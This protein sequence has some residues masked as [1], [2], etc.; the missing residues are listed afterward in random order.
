M[1]KEKAKLLATRQSEKIKEKLPVWKLIYNAYKGGSAFINKENLFQYRIE[2]NT[3]YDKRLERADYTNHIQQLVDLM[4]G[5]VY[6]KPVR[7]DLDE[8]YSYITNS[9]FKG[10]DIQI[11]MNMVASNCLKSTVGLLVDSPKLEAMTEA[12]RIANNIN[13]YV[14]YYNPEQICDF[15]T[16]DDGR[17]IWILLDNSYLDKTDPYSEPKYKTIRRLWTTEYYQ[18]IETIKND[19]AVE[20]ILS[21]EI[22]HKLPEI[23]FIFV[24]CR[25]NDADMICDSPFEDIVYKSRTV[26]NMN[27]WASEVLASSSFQVLMFP[28]ESAEDIAAIEATFSPASGG[29]SDLPVIPF[30]ATTQKPSFEGPDI[31]IEKF[32]MMINH[33]T[34]EILFKFGFKRE[35]KGSWESGVAK[36][37]DFEKTEAFLK[38]LSLQLQYAERRIVELCGMYEQDDIDCRINYSFSYEKADID[39]ELLRLANAFTVPSVTT[40][41]KAYKEIVSAIF[42]DIENDE[43]A[44][45][46]GEIE[47]NGMSAPKSDNQSTD[48][49]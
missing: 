17:L 43:L 41:N 47:K 45:I 42:P 39:K 11:L 24:N 30:K 36:S 14:V 3:R 4:V 20:Y 37:I 1:S 35:T 15:E 33:L 48:L 8:K 28:Y 23:P 13:P 25:D 29:I 19:E 46:A 32:V 40:R 22:E 6:S 49:K 18:D 34:D 10:K 27:S 7:R 16:D 21:E 31:D 38:S 5:F 26:F 12:D 2:D 9:I 44:K